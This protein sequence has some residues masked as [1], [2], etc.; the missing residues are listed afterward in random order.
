M[1]VD[2]IPLVMF[3]ELAY[4][5]PRKSANPVVDRYRAERRAIT[6]AKKQFTK[7]N[8]T[9]LLLR[10]IE[11]LASNA[12]AYKGKNGEGLYARATV[13][14]AV[15]ALDHFIDL[16]FD[17][18]SSESKKREIE[19]A[20]Q[21]LKKNRGIG[22]TVGAKWQAMVAYY[23]LSRFPPKAPPFS[24]LTTLVKRRNDLVHFYQKQVQSRNR[25]GVPN[26]LREVNCET[27]EE[28]CNTVKQMISAFYREAS[29]TPPTWL[30]AE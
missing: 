5:E 13:I 19:R 7:I 17:R 1:R 3:P 25:H 16:Y 24:D 9:P 15:I 22:T 28:A 6:M 4:S 2:S 23:T 27:A 20:I 18:I 10:D 11:D 12:R 14:I 30:N 8:S 29:R 26:L 21:R